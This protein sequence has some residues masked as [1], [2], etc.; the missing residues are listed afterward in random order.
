MSRC[1]STVGKE[2]CPSHTRT[3]PAHGTDVRWVLVNHGAAPHARV[4]RHG[5][6]GDDVYYYNCQRLKLEGEAENMCDLGYFI[7]G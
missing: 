3:G 6:L 1:T 7:I 2:G 5:V 4:A